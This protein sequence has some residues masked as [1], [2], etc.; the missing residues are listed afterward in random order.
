MIESYQE[1]KALEFHEPED[2]T[3]ATIGAVYADGVSLIFDGSEQASQ[4]HYKVNSFIVFAAGNRVRII[5][6]SGTYVVEYPVGNPK[7]TFIA[8]YAS[9]T[10]NVRN[11]RNSVYDIQFYSAATNELR[12]RIGNGAWYKLANA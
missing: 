8:T 11:M 6:D 1:E 9:G 10:S 4:K 3:F 12:F 2:A 7:I 5:K